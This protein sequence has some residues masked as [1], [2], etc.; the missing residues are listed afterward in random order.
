MMPDECFVRLGAFSALYSTASWNLYT[1]LK[2]NGR[3]SSSCIGIGH[4]FGVMFSDAKDE[5]WA[6]HKRLHDL[7]NCHNA[8]ISL[9]SR[10]V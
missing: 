10:G 4:E 5:A 6:Q 3:Y 1:F 7:R 9:S 2:S 8:S